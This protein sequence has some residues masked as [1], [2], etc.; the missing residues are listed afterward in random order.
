MTGQLN[1]LCWRP[2]DLISQLR[3]RIAAPISNGEIDAIESKLGRVAAL[4]AVQVCIP[5][6]A[7]QAKKALIFVLRRTALDFQDLG[8]FSP[9]SSSL[10]MRSGC[11]L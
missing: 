10:P 3:N 4:S 1:P 9:R 11:M 8:P 5:Y 6:V 7:S 2:P